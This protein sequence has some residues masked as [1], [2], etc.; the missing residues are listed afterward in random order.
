MSQTIYGY[1]HL[2]DDRLWDAC[3]SL[4]C[5]V[6]KRIQPLLCHFAV[7]LR[8]SFTFHPVPFECL[9]CFLANFVGVKNWRRPFATCGGGNS[10]CQ[11]MTACY[12][13]TITIT[14][15]HLVDELFIMKTAIFAI[16]GGLFKSLLLRIWWNVKRPNWVQNTWW[17]FQFWQIH[18]STWTVNC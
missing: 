15:L 17:G 9:V 7:K 3:R 4:F 8:C 11:K 14:I 1:H 10:T 13:P 18:G 5:Y 6:W 12:Y 2:Q 16:L